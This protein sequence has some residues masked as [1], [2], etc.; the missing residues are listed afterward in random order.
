MHNYLIKERRIALVA[1]M[2]VYLFFRKK[3][4]GIYDTADTL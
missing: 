1:V 4:N 2:A 3:R